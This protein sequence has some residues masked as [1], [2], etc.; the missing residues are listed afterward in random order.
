MW[1]SLLADS[2]FMMLILFRTTTK[3]ASTIK[4]IALTTSP[5]C[6][7]PWIVL[8]LRRKHISCIY[9]QII[10]TYFLT[11]Q[12]RERFWWGIGWVRVEGSINQGPKKGSY[13]C[14]A[15]I[16]ALSLL[17]EL[18]SR[19]KRGPKSRRKCHILA[20]VL[21]SWAVFCDHKGWDIQWLNQ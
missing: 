7:T 10:N 3:I 1:A 5:I 20:L 21:L 9:L 18:P 17:Q 8:G 12:F 2:A 14:F 13:L 15:R 16:K 4:G 6:N 19:A 11:S